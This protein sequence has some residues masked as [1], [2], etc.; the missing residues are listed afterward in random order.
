LSSFNAARSLMALA[1]NVDGLI[2]VDN[3]KFLRW[4]MSM[5]ESYRVINRKIV[6]RMRLIAEASEGPTA[7]EKVLDAADILNTIC[8][9][10]RIAAQVG[11][12]VMQAKG[13]NKAPLAAELSTIGYAS[14]MLPRW[15]VIKLRK[16]TNPMWRARRII[17]LT[18]TALSETLIDATFEQ[19]S[20]SLI[21]VVGPRDEIDM[22][23]FVAAR[24]WLGKLS[25]GGEV[26]G[27]DYPVK[28]NQLEVI[29]AFGG[30][31][32]IPRVTQL[33]EMGKEY[34]AIRPDMV[35]D[36]ENRLGQLYAPSA[37]IEPMG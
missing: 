16:K 27:G 28:S 12:D 30:L 21:L 7:G 2:L 4:G 11:E 10:A 18:K 14:E 6:R 26:R 20:Q 15:P 36:K 5:H 32:E 8:G 25:H 24:T 33:L 3:D 17:T 35:R 37:D 13:E 31:T 29:V 9:T 34:T 19:A 1:G 23:G 22:E